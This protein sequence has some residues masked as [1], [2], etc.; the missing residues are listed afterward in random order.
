MNNSFL[1]SIEMPYLRKIQMP[2]LIKGYHKIVYPIGLGI[3]SESNLLKKIQ[4]I[5]NRNKP[6]SSIILFIYD[7]SYVVFSTR[8]TSKEAFVESMFD[9]SLKG[10][11]VGLNVVK[12][13]DINGT[14]LKLIVAPT[15]DYS[16]SNINS[17]VIDSIIQN[18]DWN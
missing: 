3:L 8:F 2:S 17:E 15:N 10:N 18:M 16:Y 1:P 13:Y 9:Y 12:G 6:P 4:K 11:I 14:S 5:G 7:G